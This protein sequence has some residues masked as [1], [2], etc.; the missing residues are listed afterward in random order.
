ME[1]TARILLQNIA[2]FDR[3]DAYCMAIQGKIGNLREEFPDVATIGL[4]T[5]DHIVQ[6]IQVECNSVLCDDIKTPRKKGEEND[7]TK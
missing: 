1:M 2:K 6:E 7:S 4:S 3:I 5:I